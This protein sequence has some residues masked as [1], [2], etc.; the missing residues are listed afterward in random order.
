VIIVSYLS[1][2]LGFKLQNNP[3]INLN[4][5]NALG[6]LISAIQKIFSSVS[7]VVTTFSKI[8]TESRIVSTF[9]KVHENWNFERDINTNIEYLKIER[10]E[11]AI[12]RTRNVLHDLFE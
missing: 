9:F 2:F 7:S 6:N 8:Q 10:E 5:P 12:S 4:V 1:S 3:S 11:T